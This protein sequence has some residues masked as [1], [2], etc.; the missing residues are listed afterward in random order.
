MC[1]KMYQLGTFVL[2]KSNLNNDLHEVQLK[3]NY[4]LRTGSP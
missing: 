1:S 2:Q 4:F 3:R